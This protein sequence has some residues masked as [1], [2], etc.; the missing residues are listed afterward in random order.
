MVR[1]HTCCSQKLFIWSWDKETLSLLSLSACEAAK[2]EGSHPR[3]VFPAP[4]LQSLHLGATHSLLAP[5]TVTWSGPLRL[6]AF[7][8]TTSSLPKV[9]L[10]AGQSELVRH[11]WISKR[12][13][14]QFPASAR[15]LL[16]NNYFDFCQ[17]HFG[18]KR[19]HVVHQGKLFVPTFVL[20]N[21]TLPPPSN[22]NNTYCKI[23]KQVLLAP[24]RFTIPSLLLLRSTE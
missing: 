1:L 21:V 24:S 2:H 16:Y 10:W 7:L 12:R 22:K 23:A 19:K 14:L 11:H 18:L 20:Q 9:T 13:R 6:R 5:L 15:N 4:C 3:L 8:W 17:G